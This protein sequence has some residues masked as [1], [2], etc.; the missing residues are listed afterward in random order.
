M[1][2]HGRLAAI[3]IGLTIT[4]LVLLADQEKDLEELGKKVPDT[5][6]QF[7]AKDSTL[8]NFFHQAHGYV[9]FPRVSKGGFVV[10]GA[11]GKGLVYEEGTLIGSATLSQGTFGAQIGGQV[12]SEV[13]FFETAAALDSFKRSKFVMS[14]QVGA[15]AAA[16][17]VGQTA[18]YENGVAVF[19]LVQGGLM[20][21]ASVGGQKFDFKPLKP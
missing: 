14:A 16:E 2:M 7:K 11:G 18:K 5:I 20:A 4:T 8:S 12:F 21:E 10:G 17:G 15:V 1:R 6:A 3:G 19:T 9:I 13:I